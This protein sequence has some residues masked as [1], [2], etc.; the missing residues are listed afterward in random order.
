MGH[1]PPNLSGKLPAV[2]AW[3]ADWEARRDLMVRDGLPLYIREVRINP[4]E[5]GF[6]AVYV[7]IADELLPRSAAG[8]ELHYSLGYLKVLTDRGHP[9]QAIRDLVAELN[10]RYAG[11]THVARISHM[12][13]G[14]TAVFHPDEAL[15]ADPI[16]DFERRG[17]ASSGRLSLTTSASRHSHAYFFVRW[18]KLVRPNDPLPR[19]I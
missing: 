5:W 8:Y 2:M 18:S 10:R 15:L 3:Y 16:I 6:I 1:Q 19:V 13:C 7:D 17:A 4:G 12:S 11:K 14:G 9:E